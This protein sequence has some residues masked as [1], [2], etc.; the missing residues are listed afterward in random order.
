MTAESLDPFLQQIAEKN[1]VR[2]LKED[3]LISGD[4]HSVFLKLYAYEA[5]RGFLLLRSR[6][7]IFSILDSNAASPAG[8]AAPCE[9]S[10]RVQRS[11]V[12]G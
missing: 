11:V 4:I 2:V 9:F 3:F 7:V 10:E 12:R 1:P 6:A 5:F 8:R